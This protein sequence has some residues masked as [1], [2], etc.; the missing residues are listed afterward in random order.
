MDKHAAVFL[1]EVFYCAGV[2]VN[3]KRSGDR[4]GEFLIWK[5]DARNLRLERTSDEGAKKAAVGS[6]TVEA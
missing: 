1:V 6:I 5:C 4:A 3:L 2:W